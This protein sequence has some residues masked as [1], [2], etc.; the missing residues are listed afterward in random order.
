MAFP[1][2]Y[3][4]SDRLELQNWEQLKH[5]QRE[6]KLGGL[7]KGVGPKSAPL[8]F[9]RALA[10]SSIDVG[11]EQAKMSFWGV[12]VMVMDLKGRTEIS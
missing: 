11:T 7:K 8:P 6:R 3:T 4:A 12:M 5:L 10:S 9:S 1:Q 2:T